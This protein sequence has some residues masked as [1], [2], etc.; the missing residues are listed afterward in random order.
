MPAAAPQSNQDNSMSIL[1]TIAGLMAAVFAIWY[2]FQTQIVHFYLH[3]KLFEINYFLKF[4]TSRLDD[5]R[6]VIQNSLVS[7]VKKI[8]FDDLSNIGDAVGSYLRYPVILLIMSMAGLVFFASTTRVFKN[9]YSMFSLARLEKTNWPQT[10][11]ILN[12]DLAKQDVNKGPWAM[13]LLPMQFCKKH[14]LLQEFERDIQ[15]GVLQKNSS[16]VEV[17]LKRGDANRVFA[18]QLGSVWPGINRVPP[19]VRALFAVF[20]ARINGDSKPAAAVLNHINISSAT[21]L[22]FST[23]EPLIK[24]HIDTPIVKQILQS[25]AYLLTVMAEMLY[26]AR[27]DGVQ[28]TADFLW[29][30]P[31]DRRLWYMLNTVGRQ[32]PFPEVA[33]PFSHWIA[34]KKAGRKLLVPMI[35]EATNALEGA[36]KEIIY[37]P[38]EG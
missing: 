6:A 32:T 14:G 38:D 23:V 4:F 26:A 34:E 2:V 13:A 22:D 16:R 28:A 11:P 30:K 10:T 9:T 36:L 18:M 31:I 25:H 5:A 15:E 33:G 7:D 19:H 29:L 1:W 17:S 8:S 3:L 24:K 37:R 27:S 35:E 12:L 20:A 21:K